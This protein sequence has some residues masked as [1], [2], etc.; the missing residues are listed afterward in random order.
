M[1]FLKPL[2]FVLG[3]L[4]FTSF[5]DED[6]SEELLVGT[7][8][9]LSIVNSNCSDPDENDSQFFGNAGCD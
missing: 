9:A 6:N 5:G 4:F 3:F 2:F 7:W 8:E 1:K